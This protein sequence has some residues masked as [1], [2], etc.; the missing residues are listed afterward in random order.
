MLAMPGATTI[1]RV[2]NESS[3]AAGQMLRGRGTP[4]TTRTVAP[5]VELRG[6]L[7]HGCPRLAVELERPDSDA[8]KLHEEVSL[9]RQPIVR[10]FT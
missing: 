5:L 10:F 9:S 8:P 3:S 1:R 6:R 2:V 7:G 4:G